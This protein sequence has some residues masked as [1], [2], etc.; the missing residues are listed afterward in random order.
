MAVLF[1]LVRGAHDGLFISLKLAVVLGLG[2]LITIT[3]FESVGGLVRGW[4]NTSNEAGRAVGYWTVLLI[5]CGFGSYLA[6]ML[7]HE[8]VDF[9]PYLDKIC[10]AALGVLSA[11]LILGMLGIGWLITPKPKSLQQYDPSDL[12]FQPHEVVLS[13]YSAIAKKLSGGRTFD[14]KFILTYTVRVVSFV[15]KREGHAGIVVESIPS[16]LK[17][18]SDTQGNYT[19]YMFLR[20]IKKNFA[21]QKEPV[22]D[23]R[24]VGYMGKTPFYMPV[25]G[26]S[27]PVIVVVKPIGADEDT[28]SYFDDGSDQR[29]EVI[30]GR[31]VLLRAYMRRGTGMSTSVIALFQKKSDTDYRLVDKSYPRLLRFEEFDDAKM[32]ERLVSM[33]AQEDVDKLLELLHRGGK[34]LFNLKDSPRFLEITGKGDDKRRTGV[35]R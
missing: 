16:G 12:W 23:E 14:T 20:M 28:N 17:V 1:F 35:V 2:F 26:L 30:D 15:Y 34:V 25:M 4:F 29:V 18:Y 5:S 10:G 22:K 27:R 13:G 11:L 8:A 3:L 6:L 7:L 24:P 19:S 32:R 9:H 31:K 21:A 33:G